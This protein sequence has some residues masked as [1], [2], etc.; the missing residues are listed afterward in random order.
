MAVDVGRAHAARHVHG[1]EDRGLVGRDAEHDATGRAERD[2]PAPRRPPRTART[3]GAAGGARRRAAPRGSA[4]GSSSARRPGVA[5]AGSRGRRATRIGTSEEE[6]EQAEPQERSWQPP[7]RPA[8]ATATPADDQQQE[9]G[10]G[11]QGRDLDRLGSGRPAAARGPGRSPRR[12]R[13]RRPR[14]TCRR[15]SRRSCE[16]RLVQL[17]VDLEPVEVE[18][19]A[20]RAA[21]ADREDPDAR[22]RRRPGRP[23]AGR[24]ARCSRR[25]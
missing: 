1:E 21:D 8:R 15:S 22:G 19:G 24:D 18:V 5:G 25:R 16:R 17:G 13:R 6:R 20:G 9:P 3:A 4:T 7:A 2:R 10:A 14:G 23:P 11:E 12:R